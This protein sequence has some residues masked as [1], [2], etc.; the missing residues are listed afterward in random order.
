[1][2]S[3]RGHFSGRECAEGRRGAALFL[4]VAA[5]EDETQAVPAADQAQGFVDFSPPQRFWKY[6]RE[7]DANSLIALQ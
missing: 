1:M 7:G 3:P 5:G 6:A 4:L 2:S